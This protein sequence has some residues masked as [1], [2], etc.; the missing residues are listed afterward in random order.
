M[1]SREQAHSAIVSVETSTEAQ[2]LPDAVLPGLCLARCCRAYSGRGVGGHRQTRAY[3][4]GVTRT[5]VYKIMTG[6]RC[7][8]IQET[9]ADA[10]C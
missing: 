10:N 6:G 1:R 8:E 2:L 7:N 5:P 3:A 4:R 9:H